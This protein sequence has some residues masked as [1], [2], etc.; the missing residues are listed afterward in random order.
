MTNTKKVTIELT[1]D[2]IANLEMIV[3]CSNYMDSGLCEYANGDLE[4]VRESRNEVNRGIRFL[5]EMIKNA[6]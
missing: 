4:S 1:E 2:M 5:Q 6:K 3:E